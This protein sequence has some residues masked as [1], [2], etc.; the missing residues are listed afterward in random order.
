MNPIGEGDEII[1][2]SKYTSSSLNFVIK[3]ESIKN[4]SIYFVYSI[5]KGVNGKVIN[6]FREFI[7]FDINTDLVEEEKN[8]IYY[9]HSFFIKYNY[10]FG[11]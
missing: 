9:D 5:N 2:T 6:N 1:Y 11:L 8:E 7:D 4:S 3:S 10:W